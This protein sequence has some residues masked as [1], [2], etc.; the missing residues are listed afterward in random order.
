MMV[1]KIAK[2]FI[3]ENGNK[4]IMLEDLDQWLHAFSIKNKIKNEINIKALKTTID[5]IN[6]SAA[7]KKINESP[8][9]K[10]MNESKLVKEFIL[11]IKNGKAKKAE[12]NLKNI[13]DIKIQE[14]I[15]DAKS[16]V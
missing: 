2:L 4:D 3:E 9:N 13:V 15:K 8:R 1:S 5:K 14:K 12:E 10:K 7:K 11:N 16:Q 6:K